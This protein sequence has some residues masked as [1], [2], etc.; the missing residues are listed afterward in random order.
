MR[1]RQLPGMILFST[2][3]LTCLKANAD[4]LRLPPPIVPM[5]IR[6]PCGGFSDSWSVHCRRDRNGNMNDK[7][8]GKIYD[9]NGNLLHRNTND[10]S[11][12]SEPKSKPSLTEDSYKQGVKLSQAGKYREAIAVFNR[13]IAAKPTAGGYYVRGLAFLLLSSWN[14]AL[15]DLNQAIYLSPKLAEAYSLRGVVKYNG[16]GNLSAALSD[17]NQSIRLNPNLAP[18]YNNRGFVLYDQGNI[19]EAIQ[20]WQKA[21]SLDGRAAESYMALAV[22]LNIQGDSAQARQ[23]GAKAFRLDRR[24]GDVKLLKQEHHWSDRILRDASKLFGSSGKLSLQPESIIGVGLQIKLDEKT[25]KLV[26]QKSI[27]GS[28]AARAGIL[29]RDVIVSINSMSTKG[30][31]V[32]QAVNLIKGPVNTDVTLG[33]LRGDQPLEFTMQRTKVV[34]STDQH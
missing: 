4:L 26:V 33:I 15:A 27:D 24:L 30:M 23:L 34:I 10:N 18:T 1:I 12:P 9:R 14:S 16:L 31:G 13:A 28:P 6:D 29:S 8:T 20:D 32:E 17:L 2:I 7:N 21:I 3:L 25:K 11:V 5:P 19:S 22:A